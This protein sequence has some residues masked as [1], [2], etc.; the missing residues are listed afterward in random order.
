MRNIKSDELLTQRRR[1]RIYNIDLFAATTENVGV[2]VACV[3]YSS[4]SGSK[5]YNII[6]IYIIIISKF[7]TQCTGDDVILRF[8]IITTRIFTLVIVTNF[9][10]DSYLCGFL[11]GPAASRLRA[12][13]RRRAQGASE[14]ENN[15]IML[16]YTKLPYT[17]KP[18]P[19]R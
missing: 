11:Y 2:K 13:R 8:V 14:N 6:Y 7:S 12:N 3:R 18:H 1:R 15:T 5:D 4:G 16:L 9:F 19:R 10:F 17:R